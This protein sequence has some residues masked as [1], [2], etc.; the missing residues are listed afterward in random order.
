M[1]LI[2]G[3]VECFNAKQPIIPIIINS[4]GGCVYSSISICDTLKAAPDD[5]KIVTIVSGAC[6]SA[7]VLIFSCGAERIILR[8]G[9]VMIHDVVVSNLEGSLSNIR[10]EHAEMQRINTTMFRLVARHCGH[11]DI[12]YFL[13]LK[14]SN[15]DHYLSPDECLKTKLATAIVDRMPT[16]HTTVSV[17]MHLDVKHE[18]EE[19]GQL[20]PAKRAKNNK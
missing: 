19:E 5:C 14:Q 2:E 1:E 13:K 4:E 9:V 18:P 20:P 11:S 6:M 3:L 17:N 7:S 15:T 10:S 12:D 16:M 8:D